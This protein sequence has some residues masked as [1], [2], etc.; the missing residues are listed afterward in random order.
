MA[1]C[2]RKPRSNRHGK[3]G[4]PHSGQPPL[5]S[6]ADGQRHHTHDHLVDTPEACAAPGG[7]P[8]LLMT[9]PE[10]PSQTAAS[11]LPGCTPV[12]VLGQGS[13]GTVVLVRE[14][15]TGALFAAKIMSKALLVEERQVANVV[16]ERRILREAGA[17]SHPFVVKCY[18]GFQTPHA[19][20]LVL[21]YLPGGDMY[22]LL[23]QHGCLEEAQA[24]FYIAEI[25]AGLQEL[26]R[27]R[28]VYRDLKLENILIDQR[29]HIRLTDFG[30]SGKVSSSAWDDRTVFDR[31]GTAMYQAPEIIA[32]AG[33]GQ[34]VDFWALG[35]LTHV[36]LTGRAPFAGRNHAELYSEIHARNL[37][38][39][40]EQGLTHVSQNTRNFIAALLQ[41]DPSKRLGAS[42]GGSGDPCA[43]IRAHPFFDGIDW[44]ALLRLEITPP[45]PSPLS[46]PEE[47]P[48]SK[49]WNTMPTGSVAL[50]TAPTTVSGA[51]EVHRVLC[52][53]LAE[54]T[55]GRKRRQR[56]IRPDQDKPIE[57]D[58]Y[59]LVHAESFGKAG[60]VSIGLDFEGTNITADKKTWTGSSN[61]FGRV[62]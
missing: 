53:K 30:L 12:R 10:T 34:L 16:T 13:F 55:A 47:Q 44:D 50:R 8:S 31:S 35:V 2:F 42:A 49:A 17:S 36:M 52:D 40:A 57:I 27:H 62:L 25:L 48:N 3:A 24:R 43:T 5:A 54:N 37:D 60:R 56:S 38:L 28:F 32:K 1:C 20:V 41:R 26:H 39:D 9:T 15:A 58:D 61:D 59:R 14:R 23:K 46:A 22:D 11:V 33:H 6:K 7:S 4:P 19:V 29:G 21:E 45:L 18:A 51:A